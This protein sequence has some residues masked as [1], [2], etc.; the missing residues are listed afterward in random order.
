MSGRNIKYELVLLKRL[1]AENIAA[2]EH[3]HAELCKFPSYE[4][5]VG[6]KDK[7]NE[8][9]AERKRIELKIKRREEK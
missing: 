1:L 7:A 3:T 5:I 9:V 2:L 8:L 4:K 6:L